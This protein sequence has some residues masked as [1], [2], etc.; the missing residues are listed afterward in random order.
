M[1]SEVYR[2]EEHKQLRDDY[3]WEEPSKELDE[4]VLL[5]EPMGEYI[6]LVPEDRERDDHPSDLPFWPIGEVHEHFDTVCVEYEEVDIDEWNSYI[7]DEKSEKLVLQDIPLSKG[8]F[9]RYM[10][11][12]EY[13]TEEATRKYHPIHENLVFIE[14]TQIKERKN[15]SDSHRP[16]EHHGT[17]GDGGKEENKTRAVE[18][19]II[20]ILIVLSR[21][22]TPHKWRH[23]EKAQETSKSQ[24]YEYRRFQAL[25]SI[26]VERI[27][28]KRSK[29]YNSHLRQVF[30]DTREL[31]TLAEQG[32][33][34]R[35][36]ERYHTRDNRLHEYRLR[37]LIDNVLHRGQIYKEPSNHEYEYHRQREPYRHVLQD[38][39]DIPDMYL[40]KDI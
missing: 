29:G 25:E 11:E 20:H 38:S 13:G 34:H 36:E 9:F 32:H 10:R 2:I 17:S 18:V 7:F 35:Q 27:I 19:A 14:H 4:G 5:S 16:K 37:V 33:A 23:E 8:L 12:R 22:Y 26:S 40:P 3:P 31:L 30:T 39:S 1:D 24:E 21:K 15:T 6:H 28:E